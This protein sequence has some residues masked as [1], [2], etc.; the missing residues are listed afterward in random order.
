MKKKTHEK[1]VAELLAKGIVYKPIESYNG[2]L[3]KILHK[4]PIPDHPPWLI[5]P[6]NILHGY[7]CR[8]CHLKKKRKT[9]EEY[10]AELL[11]MGI[12]YRPLEKYKG[13]LTK[14]L[15]ECPVEGHPQ[16]AITP[17]DILQGK[18]CPACST[19]QKKTHEEYVAGLI[20]KGIIYKP[21]EHYINSRTKILHECPVEG[22]RPWYITPHNILQG[23]RCPACSK[24]GFDSTKPSKLYFLS[25]EHNE[26]TYYKVGITN[27]TTQERHSADW[28]P[29][30]IQ[31][32]WELDFESGAEARKLEKQI[33]E[34]NNMF[35]INTGALRSGN[36]ET[37]TVF[38]KP[39]EYA[40]LAQR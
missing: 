25:F 4:C 28:K 37:F 39:P 12:V 33:L 38:I 7:G 27:R 11:F 5:T 16:W 3:T 22:H 19:T 10:V 32:L 26:I 36:T 30:N 1:Y 34:D 14:I 13:A 20:D 18:G 8:A 24:S 35:L 15:H 9:H 21:I 6:N 31:L 40:A 2:A 23:N 29:L 17:A